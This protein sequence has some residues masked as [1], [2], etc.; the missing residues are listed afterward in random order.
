MGNEQ[1]VSMVKRRGFLTAIGGAAFLNEATLAQNSFIQGA[2]EGGVMINSNEF[3]LGPCAEALEAVKATAANGGRYLFGEAPKLAEAGAAAEGVAASHCAAFAGSSDPLHRVV[4]AYCGKGMPLV[5][6]SPGY[7]SPEGA[8]AFLGVPIHR[9]PLRQPDYA[10]DVGAMLK[11]AAGKPALFYV[12]TPNNPTGTVTP[13][14]ELERLVKEMA[15][16]SCA[17]IDEA[18]VHFADVASALMLINGPKD[19]AV[20][21]TFSKI[22]GMAG[23]RAGLVY[24]KPEVLGRIRPYGVGFV[25]TT[26][27]VG[28]RVS[29]GVKGLVEQRR[30]YVRKVREDLCNWLDAREI[31]YIPSV[32][33][34]VMIDAGRPGREL[35]GALARERVYVGRSWPSMPNHV[36]VTIGTPEEMGAFKAAMAK[37]RAAV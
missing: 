6:A 11:A 7:E 36:R 26:G 31:G 2:A 10:H 5:T 21:R 20:L 13:L 24:A 25:P 35:A 18:Y 33:N 17:L 16:G 23:L 22:Y 27:M 8:A 19:V 37:V 32:S 14:D 28:A 4:L 9:V 15:A 30:E 29:L 1:R 12:T 3:P 34:K